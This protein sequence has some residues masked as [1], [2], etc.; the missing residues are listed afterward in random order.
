[1]FEDDDRVITFDMHGA[2]NYPWKTKTK[3]N[4]DIGLPDDTGDEHYLATLAEWLPHLIELHDPSLLFFQVVYSCLLTDV[5][6]PYLSLLFTYKISFFTK[7]I[8]F[9]FILCTGT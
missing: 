5:R 8:T 3:S 6:V 2:G 4:Y 9:C 1:M 7:Q